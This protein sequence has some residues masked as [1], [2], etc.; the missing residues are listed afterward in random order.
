MLRWTCFGFAS[1]ALFARSVSFRSAFLF[2]VLMMVAISFRHREGISCSFGRYSRFNVRAADCMGLSMSMLGYSCSCSYSYSCVPGVVLVV[3][4]ACCRGDG[5]PCRTGSVGLFD[6]AGYD[7]GWW[8][9]CGR[10]AVGFR[11]GGVAVPLAVLAFF[12]S[13][14]RAAFRRPVR[15]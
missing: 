5:F 4:V 6:V 7:C 2:A 8:A 11:A 13:S 14:V 15:R 12:R 1:Y 3:L 9:D 10:A